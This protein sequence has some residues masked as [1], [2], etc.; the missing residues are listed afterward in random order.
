MK[1]FSPALQVPVSHTSS[2]PLR[3]ILYTRTVDCIYPTALHMSHSLFYAYIPTTVQSAHDV[4]MDHCGDCGPLGT[5]P[6][7]VHTKGV[8]T[9]ERVKHFYISGFQRSK[10]R[11]HNKILSLGRIGEI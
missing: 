11:K 2:F 5:F 1:L 8:S 3:D 10:E 9:R 4:I 6:H 7:I